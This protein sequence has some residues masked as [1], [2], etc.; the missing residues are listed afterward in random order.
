MSDRVIA[1]RRAGPADLATVRDLFLE[2]ARSLSFDL[3]FQNFD[4]E[5]S[6]LPGKYAPPGG[7]ILLAEGEGR[8]LGVV[9]LRP[10]DAPACE[11]KR[12]YVRPE[13]RGL[14]LGA[15]LARAVID[16]A[17][18]IGY[19]VLRLDTHESMREA[20]GLYRTL[21]FR[22]IPSYAGNP[23]PGLHYFELPIPR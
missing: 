11:M 14:G 15:R 19:A 2:Y 10:L 17:R 22:D 23:A 18:R 6:E 12:L 13:A 4:Q 3:C 8:V 7:C 9:A 20:I 21:G 5:L 16:E 1:I